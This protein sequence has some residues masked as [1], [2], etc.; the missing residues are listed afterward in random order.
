MCKKGAYECANDSFLS[1]EILQC[2]T[3]F[4]MTHNTTPPMWKYINNNNI[5]AQ[6]KY[7]FWVTWGL[8][9]FM[10]AL[11][12]SHHHTFWWETTETDCDRNGAAKPASFKCAYYNWY[13]TYWWRFVLIFLKVSIWRHIEAWKAKVSVRK[14][15]GESMQ[16]ATFMWT[17]MRLS[18]LWSSLWF[19]HILEASL[20]IEEQ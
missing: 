17:V 16:F 12:P 5:Y 19:Y 14:K 3:V 6:C 10:I 1:H 13:R 8:I 4:D 20:L 15:E 9:N 11:S 18:G 7:V 2:K